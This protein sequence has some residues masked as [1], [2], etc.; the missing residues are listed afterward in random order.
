VPDDQDRLQSG[1][2]RPAIARH[3]IALAIVGT[4]NLYVLSAKPC[5]QQSLGHCL[6]RYCGAANRIGG[7]DLDELLKN[8]VRQLAGCVIERRG[9][10]RAQ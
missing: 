9:S 3:Q 5:G 7:V 8:V 4:Q 10:Q 1:G 2:T 6:G